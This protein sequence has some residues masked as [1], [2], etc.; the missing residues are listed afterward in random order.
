MNTRDRERAVRTMAN[1]FIVDEPILSMTNGRWLGSEAGERILA[2]LEEVG[3]VI[4]T[5]RR[6]VGVRAT[7]ERSQC[8]DPF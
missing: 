3:F 4:H 7:L 8:A 1:M 2:E 5:P 6:R